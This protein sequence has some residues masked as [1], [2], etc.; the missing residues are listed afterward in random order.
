VD[1]R[2]DVQREV[3]TARCV[4]NLVCIL[5]GTI[6]IVE[7]S[8]DPDRPRDSED[9]SRIGG[10]PALALTKT[11]TGKRLSSITMLNEILSSGTKARRQNQWLRG[12]LGWEI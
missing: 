8:D 5:I 9:A 3:G 6:I 4:G 2:F 10:Y 11:A 12:I 7:S 1:P